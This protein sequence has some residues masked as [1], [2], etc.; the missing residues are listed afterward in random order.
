MPARSPSPL[1]LTRD[2]DFDPA[3][4]RVLGGFDAS[5]DLRSLALDLDVRIASAGAFDDVENPV[6]SVSV[7]PA[8]S[9][10]PMNLPRHR[11]KGVRRLVQVSME[12]AADLLLHRCRLD[13]GDVFDSL[14]IREVHGPV[15]G[16][17]G[18]L[19]EPHIV[20]PEPAVETCGRVV[21]ET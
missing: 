5:D 18:V 12:L 7:I 3:Q 16:D 11:L 4:G 8:D 19:V 20:V 14:Q 2:L 1:L 13:S 9:P 6:P 21:A 15:R 10:A 17:H